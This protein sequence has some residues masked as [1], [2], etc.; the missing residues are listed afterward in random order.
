VKLGFDASYLPADWVRSSVN[1]RIH[2]S[3]QRV[4]NLNASW[5]VSKTTVLRLNLDN[6]LAR[7]KARID[8]YLEQDSIVRLSTWNAN[9]ARIVLR[10]ETSL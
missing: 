7:R 8:E 3:R 4:L 2:E 6:L 10:F 5:N 9:H 1:Q